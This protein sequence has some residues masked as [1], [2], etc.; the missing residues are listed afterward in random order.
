MARLQ[1]EIGA[2]P[3][4]RDIYALVTPYLLNAGAK[5]VRATMRL[6]IR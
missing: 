3:Y 6:R 2:W 5:A 4:N 1:P